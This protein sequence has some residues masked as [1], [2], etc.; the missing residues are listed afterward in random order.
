MSTRTP[1]LV[2]LGCSDIV[3]NQRTQAYIQWAQAQ[4]KFDVKCCPSPYFSWCEDDN[5]IFTDPVTD[6]A[7]WFD[8]NFPESADFLGVYVNDLDGLENDTYTRSVSNNLSDGSSLGRGSLSGKTLTFDVVLFGTSCAGLEWGRRWLQR[9]LRGQACDHSG[10]G[11]GRC[12]TKELK[13]RACCPVPLGADDGIRIFPKAALTVGVTRADGDRRDACC[14]V[15]QRYTFV[16]TTTTNAAFSEPV[17]A[18]VDV[19]PD[20]GDVYCFDWDSCDTVATSCRCSAAC[21]GSCPDALFVSPTLINDYPCGPFERVTACCCIGGTASSSVGSALILELFS[22]SDPSNASFNA[23]G[24]TDVLIDFYPNPKMLPCPT[25]QEELETFKAVSEPCAEVNI[26]RIP[27]RASI[28]IDGRTGEALLICN[29]EETPVY[30]LVRGDLTKLVAGCYDMIACVTWNAW[31]VV[32]G[33]ASPSVSPS[34]FS[35]KTATR[36]E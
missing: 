5:A 29:G 2:C 12:G 30:D 27:P 17:D 6:E 34:R 4:G 1:S 16:L 21:D 14:D 32:F 3:N 22:G 26:C 19:M 18:C 35:V 10:R 24:A 28:K 13:I 11:T 8:P 20:S 7:C 23:S 25:T 36:F 9:T 15:Y 33:P 31:S